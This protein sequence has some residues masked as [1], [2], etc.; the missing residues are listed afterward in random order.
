VPALTIVRASVAGAS[1]AGESIDD[2]RYEIAARTERPAGIEEMRMMLRHLLIERLALQ[3]HVE[4]KDK[5]VY[6][7]TLAPG[8]PKFKESTVDGPPDFSR[9][10]VSGK[11]ALVVRRA[12]M[13]QLGAALSRKFNELIVDATA[14]HGRYD[15]AID[16]SAYAGAPGDLGLAYDDV[17]TILFSSLPAQTGLKLD[18]RR[19]FV[20]MLIVDHVGSPAEN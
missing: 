20:E 11:T 16:I 17:L 6:A 13:A 3:T 14:L 4:K 10:I 15:L 8:G 7:L 12:T 18:S 1:I 9:S 5:R 19:Q 2:L